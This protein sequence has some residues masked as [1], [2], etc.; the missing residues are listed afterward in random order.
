MTKQ[1]QVIADSRFG[2]GQDFLDEVHARILERAKNYP[3]ELRFDNP[4][5]LTFPGECG[6]EKTHQIRRTYYVSKTSGKGC[7]YTMV[8]DMVGY[9]VPLDKVGQS[10]ENGFVQY[11]RRRK[12]ET[13]A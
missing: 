7:I 2:K 12:A 8:N 10:R 11:N 1:F 4:Y 3:V 13:A 5:P 6:E 9:G